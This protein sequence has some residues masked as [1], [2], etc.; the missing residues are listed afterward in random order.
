[1][2][3]RDLHRWTLA[4]AEAIEIQ[5]RLAAQ[6]I[7]Q[8][9]T[10]PVRH[11]AGADVAAGRAGQAGRGAVVL[12]SFPALE[13]ADVYTAEQPLSMPY[14]PGLLAFRELPALLAAF[15]GLAT[16][17]DLVMVDGHGIAHPRRL[18]IAAHLGLLLDLPT[19]GCA[20]S[21]LVGRTAGE[22]GPNAGDWVPLVD[23]GEV[24]GAALRTRVGVRPVYVSIGHRVDLP[25]AIAWV[26]RC[27]RGYR[28]PEPT[29]LA[30]RAAGGTLIPT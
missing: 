19:I 17:P 18:G 2:R 10:G 8:N 22:P 7:R 24:V 11:V 26:L 12:L 27:G 1:M 6:V 23:R 15:T 28:L 30:D 3:V 13:I 21:I 4:P 29:R 20:K 25:A 9:E 16:T 14:V 5:H